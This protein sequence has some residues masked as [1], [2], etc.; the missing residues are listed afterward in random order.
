MIETWLGIAALT[1]LNI[2]GWT[3]MAVQNKQNEARLMGAFEQKLKDICDRLN[4]FDGR[5]DKMDDRIDK[6]D[7]RVDKVVLSQGR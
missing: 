1:I 4:R 6:V 7:E 2:I 5:V 3:I